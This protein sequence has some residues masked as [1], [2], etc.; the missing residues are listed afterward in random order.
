MS[1]KVDP[2]D[3]FPTFY[4]MQSVSSNAVAQAL[5]YTTT[6][7]LVGKWI[8]GANLYAKTITIQVPQYTGVS[9][10][11]YISTPNNEQ[12]REWSGNFF[13][14]TIDNPTWIMH[15]PY[16]FINATDNKFLMIYVYWNTQTHQFSL[17]LGGTYQA[18]YYHGYAVITYHY[19][20]NW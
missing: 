20:K 8:N 7:K 2:L 11:L 14:N 18:G 6:E 19:T 12:V 10:T 16:T 1:T 17:N 15:I 13:Q 5:S 4:N 9:T 3:F